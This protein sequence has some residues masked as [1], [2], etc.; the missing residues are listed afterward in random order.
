[1]ALSR[2][3][4]TAVTR[5]TGLPD[6]SVNVSLSAVAA[7]AAAPTTRVATRTRRVGWPPT[8]SVASARTSR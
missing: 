2:G 8:V 7:P 4:M 5:E 1:M 3:L 6:A